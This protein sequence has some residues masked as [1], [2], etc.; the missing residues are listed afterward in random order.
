MNRRNDI[1]PKERALNSKLVNKPVRTGKKSQKSI[2]CFAQRGEITATKETN[3]LY[4]LRLVQTRNPA[5]ALR[6]SV[7]INKAFSVAPP[8][9]TPP[10][11]SSKANTSESLQMNPLLWRIASSVG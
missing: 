5:L 4:P 11:G 9:P 6:C 3:T 10:L 7:T 1:V 8:L 2:W